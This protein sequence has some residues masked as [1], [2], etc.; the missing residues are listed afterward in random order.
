MD[1]R[2]EEAWV[3]SISG[4]RSMSGNYMIMEGVLDERSFVLTSIKAME[5]GIIFREEQLRLDNVPVFLIGCHGL[6][7]GRYGKR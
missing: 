7:I 4:R 3:L 5:V 6:T 2:M 1:L